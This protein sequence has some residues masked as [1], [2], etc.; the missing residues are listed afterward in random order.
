MDITKLSAAQFVVEGGYFHFFMDD[1]VPT[2]IVSSYSGT[3]DEIRIWDGPLPAG[4]IPGAFEVVPVLDPIRISGV[5]VDQGAGDDVTVAFQW[6]SLPG[7]TYSVD[8]STGLGDWQELTDD[9][10]SGGEET[11]YEDAV[12]AASNTGRRYYQVREN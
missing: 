1:I 11:S 10:P 3:V 7:R 4:D 8:F 9:V 5:S 6:N 2:E 12:P